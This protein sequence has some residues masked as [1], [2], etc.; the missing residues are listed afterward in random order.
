MELV[1]TALNEASIVL[2]ASSSKHIGYASD[3]TSNITR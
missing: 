2:I 3:V 1:K